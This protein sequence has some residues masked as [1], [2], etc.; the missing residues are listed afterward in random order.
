MSVLSMSLSLPPV[1]LS[2][3]V[4]RRTTRRELRPRRTRVCDFFFFGKGFGL[5]GVGLGGLWFGRVLWLWFCEWC[6]FG[7]GNN[8]FLSFFGLCFLLKMFMS[9]C[10][11]LLKTI[12]YSLF[13][14][15]FPP[16]FLPPNRE[17]PFS[18][19]SSSPTPCW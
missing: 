15:P 11:F 6:F 3:S 18:P 14:S 1:K 16:S 2:W 17:V 19:S 4:S 8:F 9:V 5:V 7:G 10:T 12:S 13:P